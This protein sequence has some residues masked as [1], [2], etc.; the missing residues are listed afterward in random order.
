MFIAHCETELT[1]YGYIQPHGS[2]VFSL[3]LQSSLRIDQSETAVKSLTAW[4][5]ESYGLRSPALVHMSCGVI[6][7]CYQ[8]I[9]CWV[10]SHHDLQNLCLYQSC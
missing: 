5:R 6:L 1:L 9:D 4:I 10:E 3:T 2:V 7:A 8:Y